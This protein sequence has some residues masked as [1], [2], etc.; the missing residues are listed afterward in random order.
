MGII[1]WLKR[2]IRGTASDDQ[3]DVE[4][5]PPAQRLTEE[6]WVRLMDLPGFD[7][8]AK[9]FDRPE[10]MIGEDLAE[11]YLLVHPRDIEAPAPGFF[12]RVCQG[13]MDAIN[14]HFAHLDLP[15]H[16]IE[17]YKQGG[18]FFDKSEHPYGNQQQPNT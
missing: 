8:W 12:D 15:K 14:E 9:E 11:F 10:R 6:L 4:E 13:R 7:E 1:D 18:K 5:S 16:T 3:S 17:D 2:A